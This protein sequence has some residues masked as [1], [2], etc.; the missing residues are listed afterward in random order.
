MKL[1]NRPMGV[2]IGPMVIW[3]WGYQK[4]GDYGMSGVTR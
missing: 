4:R 3:G 1:S 2:T